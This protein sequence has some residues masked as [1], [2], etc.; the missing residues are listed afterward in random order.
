[1]F[2]LYRLIR[3]GTPAPGR[4]TASPR[5]RASRS[6]EVFGQRKLLKWSGPGIAHF[7]TFWGFII[8]GLTIIEAYGALFDRDFP[9]P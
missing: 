1:M 2:W 9:I 8:L 7:F 5:G 4:S 3:T 6:H